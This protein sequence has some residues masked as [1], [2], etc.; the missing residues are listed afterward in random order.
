MLHNKNNVVKSKD[1]LLTVF[2]MKFSVLFFFSFS[3]CTPSR[4]ISSL[5]VQFILFLPPE[6]EQSWQFIAI[7]WNELKYYCFFQQG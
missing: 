4:S 1:I 3:P 6:A 2:Q 7:A 5:N